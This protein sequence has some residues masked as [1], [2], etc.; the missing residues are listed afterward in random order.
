MFADLVIENAAIRTMDPD[1]PFAE[2]L[3]IAG[4]RILA[5]GS[6]AAMADY[7]GP[8]TQRINA[9]GQTVL[10]GFVE[11]HM[12]LFL[13]AFSLKVLQLDEVF[14]TA[15]IAERIQAFAA[16]N[17]EE[18]LLVVQGLAYAAFD[19]DC[20]PDRHVLDGICPDRPL[21][22]QSCDFHNGWA[23]SVALDAANLR[24][25]MDVGPGAS[26]EVD[27]EGI[28]TGLLVEPPAVA[29]V[30]ALGRHG[31]REGLGLKGEEPATPVSAAERQADKALL[32][33]GLAYCAKQGI[34]TLINM[35]GNLYQAALLAE[36]EQDGDLIC[37]LE[38]PYH[39]T[40]AHDLAALDAAKTMRD[41]LDSDKLWSGRIKLFMDGVLDAETAVRL[42]DYPGKP[43]KRGEPL[44]MP[45]RFATLATRFD[46]ED[47]QIS[48]H[49]I[50]DGAVR[51]VLDGYEAAFKANGDRDL[52][53]RIEH[54]EMIDPADMPRLAA[55]G[56]VASLQPP[57][58]PGC[59]FPMEPTATI[60]G[61][62]YWRQAYPWRSLQDAG[63]MVC[64][65]SD[66]PIAP[67]APLKGID[68]AMQRTVWAN[69]LPDER[70]SFADTLAAYTA[71]GAYA[72]RKDGVFGRLMP[73]LKADLVLLDG[74]LTPET[75]A[76]TN[77]QMT[78]CDGV[79]TYQ[80]EV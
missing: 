66:W 34:T 20:D 52:R 55:L 11:S 9:H 54:I 26:V 18:P 21:L 80:A 71:N 32:R 1:R 62:D 53:H 17:P 76:K 67:L 36:I 68:Y 59:G 72:A 46:A 40:P 41:M 15:A 61:R 63:A 69:D 10:P 28:A 33:E 58:P 13:G 47:F 16:S 19:G 14:G 42:Q 27:G 74:V 44:H 73:G 51:I 6:N 65:S 39:F 57:H 38:L 30:L 12:H 3:A 22:L 50:G 77:V 24:H 5:V 45:A 43:G 49:A 7:C 29:P 35:D 37:R 60:I 75:V 2:A 23:N 8:A 70:L 79:I 31:G 64:F 25:G 48:V 56:V 4:D 78:V